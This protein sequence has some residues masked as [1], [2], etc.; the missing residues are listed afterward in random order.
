ME[1]QYLMMI[2]LTIYL[3][4]DQ[5]SNDLTYT[6]Y[7]KAIKAD[8]H[9]S[10]SL[11]RWAPHWLG[12][13]LVWKIVSYIIFVIMWSINGNSSVVPT[14]TAFF[15]VLLSQQH[16]LTGDYIR[17][18]NCI[19]HAVLQSWLLSLYRSRHVAWK[20]GSD[21]Y[22]KMAA[23]SKNDPRIGKKRERGRKDGSKGRDEEDSAQILPHWVCQKAVDFNTLK[24]ESSRAK[25]FK[26]YYNMKISLKIK[27]S[28]YS[29]IKRPKYCQYY[30][31]IT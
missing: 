9:N 1:R 15:F 6:K 10:W 14:F 16:C 25:T 19:V 22:M 12:V 23:G 5:N 4:K 11:P 30:S 18:T 24:N 7:N 29:N 26:M 31:N 27:Y 8:G 17:R 28:L 2:L 21:I 20:M 3:C 13:L